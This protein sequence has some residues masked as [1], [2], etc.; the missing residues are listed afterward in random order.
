MVSSVARAEARDIRLPLTA[1]QLSADVKVGVEA[2]PKVNPDLA[3]KFTQEL[4]QQIAK[5]RSRLLPGGE[6]F[7]VMKLLKGNAF[8][9]QP[10]RTQIDMIIKIGASSYDDKAAAVRNTMS[11][12]YTTYQANPGT[13]SH[14]SQEDWVKFVHAAQ[15]FKVQTVRV[16]SR[17][18][19]YFLSRFPDD[20]YEEEQRVNLP[21]LDEGYKTLSPRQSLSQATTLTNTELQSQLGRATGILAAEETWIDFIHRKNIIHEAP[22]ALE[23][24]QRV[25]GAIIGIHRRQGFSLGGMACAYLDVPTKYPGI[26]TWVGFDY[27][28]DPDGLYDQPLDKL[29]QEGRLSPR[30]N[31]TIPNLVFIGIEQIERANLAKP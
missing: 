21:T 6:F 26:K 13:K 5:E 1:T 9:I 10:I 15:V 30:I 23:I 27:K 17:N 8:V 29:I 22:D 4:E 19:V 3:T 25:P 20:W 12:L 11:G 14:P 24:K 18:M 16:R 7:E 2:T 28:H 31:L